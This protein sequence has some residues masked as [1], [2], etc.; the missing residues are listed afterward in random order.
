VHKQTP[1]KALGFF[2]R[3][4]EGGYQPTLMCYNF[5]LYVYEKNKAMGKSFK[6]KFV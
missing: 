4:V 2:L 3:D 1:R 6:D 5:L